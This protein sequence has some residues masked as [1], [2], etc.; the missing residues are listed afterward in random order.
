MKKGTLIT[1]FVLVALFAT[2]GTAFASTPMIEK[3][4]A[5][6]APVSGTDSEA[7]GFAAVRF[8][9]D[10]TEMRYL[11]VVKNITDVTMAHIHLE[12]PTGAPPVVWLYPDAPPARLIPGVF[13]GVL[14]RGVATDADLV[15]PLAGMTLSDLKTAIQNDLTFVNVHT[16]AFPGGEIR[17]DLH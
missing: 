6:L 12:T 7:V 13:S 9:E 3:F 5:Y 1:L 15:G 11:L 4:S 17:G 10:M 16:V 8:N 14:G 2:I